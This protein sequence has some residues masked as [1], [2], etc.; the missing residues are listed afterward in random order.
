MKLLSDAN[1]FGTIKAPTA[2]SQYGTDAGPAIGGLIEKVLQFLIV[3]AGIY[4]LFNLVLAGYAF[5]SAG[6]DA[7]K[8]EGAWAKIYQT[9]IGLAFSAGAFVLA[10]LIGQFVFGSWDFILSPSIPTL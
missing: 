8:V 5:M 2:L 3:G 4:A 9:I 10:A 6:D 7:K 1:P